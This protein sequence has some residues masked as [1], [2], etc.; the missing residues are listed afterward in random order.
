M[1]QLNKLHPDDALHI[2]AENESGNRCNE[3][4]LK[5]LPGTEKS[6]LANDENTKN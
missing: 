2:Y 3:C 4:T 1:E 6:I 5:S